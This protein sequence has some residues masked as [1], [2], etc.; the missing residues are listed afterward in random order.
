M[1]RQDLKVVQQMVVLAVMGVV[2][3]KPIMVQQ[4]YQQ[5][6]IQPLHKHPWNGI[7]RPSFPV[8]MAASAVASPVIVSEGEYKEN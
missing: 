8:M 3:R 1:A 4:L 5:H 2:V 6:Y 7:N